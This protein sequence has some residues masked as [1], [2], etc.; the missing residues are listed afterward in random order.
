MCPG[1]TTFTFLVL[2]LSLM[3]TI[4]FFGHRHNFTGYV[5][6]MRSRGRP[7]SREMHGNGDSGNTAVTTGIPQ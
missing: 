1:V 7:K 4:E 6:D 3:K 5:Q 2:S